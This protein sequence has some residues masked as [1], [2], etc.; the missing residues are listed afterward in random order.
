VGR[1]AST[2]SPVYFRCYRVRRTEG[3]DHEI[4]LTGRTRPYRP[5]RMIGSR[6]EFTS[7]EYRCSC[8]HIGWSNH[9]DLAR[10]AGAESRR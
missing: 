3:L 4:T 7:F 8:G 9:R 10:M 5:K 6:S 2:G 1:S